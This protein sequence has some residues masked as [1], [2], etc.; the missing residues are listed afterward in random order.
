MSKNMEIAE[1]FNTSTNAK[2]QNNSDLWTNEEMEGTPFR[3]VGNEKEGYTITF[4]RYRMT[5]FLKTPDDVWNAL[6]DEQ[7]KIIAQL[8]G[9]MIEINEEHKKQQNSQS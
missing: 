5:E 4:G 3:L 1:K 7:W 8:I 9:T 6:G 2:S